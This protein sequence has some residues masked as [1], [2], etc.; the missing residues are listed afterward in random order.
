MKDEQ[1]DS[2]LATRNPHVVAA[3]LRSRSGVITFYRR[4]DNARAKAYA[5]QKQNETFWS[6]ESGEL[7]QKIDNSVDKYRAS[8]EEEEKNALADEINRLRSLWQKQFGKYDEYYA[9]YAK[10]L[11]IKNFLRQNRR[12]FR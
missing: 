8:T 9:Y 2:A 1:L 6:R 4:G 12:N 10:T 5:R 11:E 7:M 3:L